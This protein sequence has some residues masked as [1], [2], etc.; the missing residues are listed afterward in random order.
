MENLNI[1]DIMVSDKMTT[2]SGVLYKV[3]FY[4][5]NI[6]NDFEERSVALEVVVNESENGDLSLV[7]AFSDDR[8]TK[9][10]ETLKQANKSEYEVHYFN[11]VKENFYKEKIIGLKNI[12]NLNISNNVLDVTLVESK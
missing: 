12:L 8:M 1:K 2:P 5:K 6:V 9:I 10:I 4:N 3:T 7:D 11:G